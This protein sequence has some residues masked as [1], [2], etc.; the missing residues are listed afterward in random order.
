MRGLI[1]ALLQRGQS[2]LRA[3]VHMF[4]RAHVFVRMFVRLFVH[5]CVCA[6][7]HM[8]TRTHT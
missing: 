3:C 8:H 5:A 2:V 7:V 6:L 1:G 4:A